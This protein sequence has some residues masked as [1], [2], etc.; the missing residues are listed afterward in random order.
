MADKNLVVIHEFG[1]LSNQKDKPVSLGEERQLPEES[2][3]NLWNF[4]LEN[5]GGKDA[6]DVMSVHIKGGRQYIKTGRYVG[7]IQTKDGQVI[8]ILPKIYKTGNQE[9]DDVKLCRRVFLRMLYAFQHSEAKT[10]Q[11]A[12]LN[13]RE[14]FP[15]LEVY[16]SR[17]LE[18]VER[19]LSDGIKKNYSIV[20]EN[21]KFL[22]GKLLFSRQISKH[23]ADKT[24]FAVR[25]SKYIENI[26]QNRIIVST[27]GKLAKTS[28]SEVNVS[29][30]YS[31]ISAFSDIPPSENIE[32]DLL[33][34]M[35][36]NRL[37]SSYKNLL[38]WSSQFLLNKGF[39]TFSG[40]HVNQSLLFSAEKLF[41]SF[42]AVL[43][44]KYAKDYI[45]SS[46]HS[47]Y[48]L[49]DKYGDTSHGKF[50]LRPDIVMESKA[51]ET[52]SD[53]DTII[54]DT[55]WKNLDSSMPDKNYLIDIK[56][57]YQLYAYGQKY[58]LG[59][60]YFLDVIPKLV[61][62]YPY[63]EKF[64]S[65]LKP[66]VYEE[67][68]AKYGLKLVVYPFNLADEGKHS[69]GYRRQIGEIMALASNPEKSAGSAQKKEMKFFEE[70]DELLSD[71]Y[72]TD[73][74][75]RYMLIG[76]CRDEKHLNWILENKL[77][78][79]RMGES[80]GALKGF[81]LQIIPSRI[82]LYTG[83]SNRNEK[84]YVYTVNQSEVLIADKQKI[85]QLNYPAG[86]RGIGEQYKLF[87]LG[88][89]IKNHKKIDIKKLKRDSG[90][91]ENSYKPLF[92]RY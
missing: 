46:Q 15:I 31:L 62:V 69:E 68:K 75:D 8:E 20:E 28:S 47:K 53:Y 7:T 6:D 39:T 72:R 85:E 65:E 67:V 79:V 74:N 83:E 13:T 50:R 32:A 64:Q 33:Q 54:I 26:P 70:P 90:R 63:T 22:K 3:E 82:V 24:R 38:Q 27:L 17:Y 81:E 77:Y 59:D 49:V 34:S 60:S 23:C 12:L 36:S 41:E 16:I 92:V 91:S 76:Y 2:F 86:S 71:E 25:Y 61:L 14:N 80:R 4:I 29:R 84:V 10:F 87:S 1:V 19:L 44:K 48:F 66:F 18:E 51:T 43:F 56:D 57:M 21:Q 78:N 30:C 5:K 35:N 45:V 89:E 9:E 73:E 52:F 88:T 37:F 11:D 55:K 42:I 40:N 58:H